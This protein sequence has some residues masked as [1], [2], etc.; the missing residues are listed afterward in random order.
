MLELPWAA[1]RAD[2]WLR[3]K[4]AER[5][6]RPAE[7]G[8]RL[9]RNVEHHCAL[10]SKAKYSLGHDSPPTTVCRHQREGCRFQSVLLKH[11][12]LSGNCRHLE[13]VKK[14]TSLSFEVWSPDSHRT[15]K[16]DGFQLLYCDDSN[17]FFNP[18]DVAKPLPRPP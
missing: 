2:C 3:G 14:K 5:R 8:A 17:F 12:E 7:E 1:E 11:H 6:E 10:G 13:I 9:L 15:V 18:H 16:L 4:P